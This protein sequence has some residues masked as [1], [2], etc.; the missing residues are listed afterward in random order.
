M[1]S[2]K[3]HPSR[4]VWTSYSKVNDEWQQTQKNAKAFDAQLAHDLA[5]RGGQEY[6]ALGLFLDISANTLQCPP[7]VVQNVCTRCMGVKE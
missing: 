3:R 6:A 5:A 4:L 2:D 7:R 1:L